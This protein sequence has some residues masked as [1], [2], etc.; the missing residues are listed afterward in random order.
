MK[1]RLE[2]ILLGALL[3]P[4][5]AW[6]APVQ[7]ESAE[8]QTQPGS[9]DRTAAPP[10]TQPAPSAQADHPSNSLPCDMHTAD[11]HPDITWT[12]SLF[13]LTRG[14]ASSATNEVVEYMTSGL[15]KFITEC[16]GNDGTVRRVFEY[17]KKSRPY[18]L[19]LH[20]FVD[21]YTYVV[22]ASY[23][24][25]NREVYNHEVSETANKRSRIKSC[26]PES[27]TSPLG[28]GQ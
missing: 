26:P 20:R 28:P 5:G 17:K 27:R 7:L 22:I 18:L 19:R 1:I 15:Y 23:P 10:A 13:C 24:T 11:A 25:R 4:A 14:T 2:A 9:A 16:N 6:M 12:T 8:Q 3:T 21:A